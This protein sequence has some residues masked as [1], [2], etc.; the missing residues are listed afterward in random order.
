[1]NFKIQILR[2][3]FRFI[4]IISPKNASS[5]AFKLFQ[6]VRIKSIRDR[7][8]DFYKKAKTFNV[9]TKKEDI[10]CYELSPENKKLVFLLHG[11]ESNAGSLTKIAYSLSANNFRVITFDL[12]GHANY[13]SNYTNLY[14]CKE[15]FKSVLKFI[16]PKTPFNVI[17]H[18]FGSAVT[19]FALAKQKYKLDNIIFLTSPNYMI[20]IFLDYKNQIKLSTKSFSYLLDIAKKVLNKE[21]KDLNIEEEINSISFSKL[22][23]IHDQNDQIIPFKNSENIALKNPSKTK[24]IKHEN[25][26]HYKMLWNDDV[27]ND[28]LKFLKKN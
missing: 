20:D 23:L 1:M 13:K 19:T 27:I 17:A 12:P 16:D 15:A 2:F 14:E 6:K 8:K 26:G 11:W 4:S 9:S 3:Y 18:S 7:E 10:F 28:I 25:I 24:L 5:I 22:L 21:V